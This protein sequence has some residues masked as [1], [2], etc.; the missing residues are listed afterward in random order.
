MLI[1]LVIK[2][3]PLLLLFDLGHIDV[4][5]DFVSVSPLVVYDFLPLFLFLSF[6]KHGHLGFLLQ[7][8]LHSEIFLLL[9]VH[10]SSPLRNYI[11]CLLPS[12]INFLVG[13]E[14][15]LFQ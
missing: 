1:I 2:K 12:L 15:F 10:V 7:F 11:S 6:V 3:L 4:L 13:P 9:S 5:L 8:H 14:L